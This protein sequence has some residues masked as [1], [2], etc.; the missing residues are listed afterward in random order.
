[1]YSVLPRASR[2]GHAAYLAILPPPDSI[3]YNDDQVFVLVTSS[4]NTGSGTTNLFSA[5]YNFY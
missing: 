4:Q 3:V 5:K 1:M 2:N